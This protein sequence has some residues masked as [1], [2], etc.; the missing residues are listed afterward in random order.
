MRI[1]I[2]DD[3]LEIS[4]QVADWSA[5][6][7]KAEIVVFNRP[8][9]VPEEAAEAL[10]DFDIICTLR[11]RMPIPRRL[12]ERLPRLKYILVTGKRYDTIDVEA[13]AEHGILVSNTKV[14]GRGGGSVTELVWG[15]ILG[16]ARN[17]P[18]EDRLMRQG[19]WQHFAG[20]TIR[21]K[22]L[23]IIGLGGLGRQVA[24]GGRFFGMDVVA[25]SQ[26]LTPERAA[27]AGARYVSKDELFKTSDFVTVHVAWSERTTGLVG[28]RELG[29]M[30]PSAYLINTARGAIVDEAALIDVLKRRMIAG[31]A[32]DVYQTEPLPADH[33]LR[34]LDNVILTPHLGYF[35]REMLAIYYGDAVAAIAAFMDGTPIGVVN[36]AARNGK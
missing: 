5:V 28:A 14:D 24:S 16:L 33:P 22:T 36:E 6:T 7:S 1:A 20:T 32:L 13:A 27:E 10:K 31:A 29:L 19:G 18:L 35:T 21:N 26:N 30:K 2:L 17:I 15:L 3:Y 4:Q 9:A 25:W 8:L 12:I 11:E 34:G 23:G